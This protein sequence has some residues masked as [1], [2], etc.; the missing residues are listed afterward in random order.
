MSDLD[1]D[2]L[3]LAGAGS[4]EEV[5]EQSDSDVPLKRTKAPV[6]SSKRRKVDEDEDEDEGDEDADEA[7]VNPYPLEG[8]YRDDADREYL[9]DLDEVEREQILFD[10]SQEME[11]YNEKKYLLQR[12]KQQKEA[13]TEKKATRASNRSTVTGAKSSKLDKL[14][15][16][17]KQR[18]QKT[19][20]T[21]DDDFD[22]E[23]EEESEEDEE[24]PDDED[25][26][27]YDDDR[28]VVWG[29]SK[30]SKF[31]PRSYVVAGYDD[32]VKIKVGRSLLHKYC[33]YTDFH[34][35]VIDTFG[36]VN[37]GVD[38]RTR[39]P[40]YRMVQII[41]VK[42]RPEKSYK[43]PNAKCDIYLLVSQNR[44]QTKEFPINVFSDGPITH[45]EFERYK[46]EL[47][48]TNE[49]LPYVDDVNEKYDQ[50]QA[51]LN[52]GLTD[53]DVNEMI[54]RKKKLSGGIQGFDAVFEKTKIMDKLK[55][56]QQQGNTEEIGKLNE[57]L[58]ELENIL[59][60]KTTQHNQSESL[61][62]MSKVNER[63]RKLNQVN[64]RKAEIE[65]SQ[66]KKQVDASQSS[67][68]FLR[69]K[70]QT[71]IFY[72]DL[73]QQENE[74][75]LNEAKENYDKLLEEKTKSEQKIASSTYRV[76][77][78]IDKIIGEIDV[79]ISLDL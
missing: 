68:P 17:K 56:A 61:N 15:E 16:L 60:N 46:H 78:N 7:L 69:L 63:N 49:E 23:E 48:K 65:S 28:E 27:G 18:E 41:D 62:T 54:E 57:R 44:N 52:R 55:I 42:S 36:K 25:D 14:S 9:L 59:I 24:Q 22:D 74:K 43:L 20:R 34:D 32:V 77:G 50:L 19:K 35:T 71:R 45:D 51:F 79:Q 3:A 8:K 4:D 10:R 5:S 31:K 2:L 75:A 29:S 37:L 21:R 40:I 70:T 26:Y 53:K 1:D 39:K 64:I 33:F 76:L 38:K 6:S 66:L 11:K 13:L 58:R 30:S 12:M 67:D 72:Q 47:A 73:R